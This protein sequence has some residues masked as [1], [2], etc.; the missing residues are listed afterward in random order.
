MKHKYSLIKRQNFLKPSPKNVLPNVSSN[1][2][3]ES[4]SALPRKSKQLTL[5]SAVTSSDFIL[6]EIRWILKAVVSGYSMN[7]L[8]E[9]SES[10]TVMFPDSKIALQMRRKRTKAS[11]IANFTT[12]PD[13]CISIESWF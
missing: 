10:L 2:V 5:D 13:F 4:S 1:T 3:S 7:S 6:A 12:A 9:I 8:N 11:Y